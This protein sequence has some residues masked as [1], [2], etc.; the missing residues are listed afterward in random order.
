MLRR[1]ITW[2]VMDDRWFDG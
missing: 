2:V 1:G